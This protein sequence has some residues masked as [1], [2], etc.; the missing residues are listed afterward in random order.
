MKYILTC[1]DGGILGPFTTIE[2]VGNGYI[3]D[4]VSYQTTVTGPVVQSEVP[5]DYINPYNVVPQPQEEVVVT[6]APIGA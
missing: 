5:D 4:N 3:A 2:Q 6:D 1:E